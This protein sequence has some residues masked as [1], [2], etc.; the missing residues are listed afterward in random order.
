ML[1]V[2]LSHCAASSADMPL[3]LD[4]ESNRLLLIMRFIGKMW[5]QH[6]QA[7]GERVRISV[8]VHQ[9]GDEPGADQSV[10]HVIPSSPAD[11]DIDFLR[12]VLRTYTDAGGPEAFS[13]GVSPFP[14]STLSNPPSSGQGDARGSQPP[15]SAPGAPPITSVRTA[16][17]GINESAVKNAAIDQA[18]ADL[19]AQRAAAAPQHERGV[20]ALAQGW[21]GP[22][23]L[24][25]TDLLPVCPALPLLDTQSR[26]AVVQSPIPLQDDHV[27]A[28]LQAI[29][30]PNLA[31]F[32]WK[33]IVLFTSCVR[34]L[35]N[36]F[37]PTRNLNRSKPWH[38]IGPN[39]ANKYTYT[40]GT[41][42]Y[43]SVSVN[44]AMVRSSGKHKLE[45][46]VTF[47]ALYTESPFWRAACAIFRTCNKDLVWDDGQ[48]LLRP[49]P[50]ETAE[51]SDESSPGAGKGGDDLG[52]LLADDGSSPSGSDDDE[53]VGERLSKRR[54]TGDSRERKKGGSQKQTGKKSSAAKRRSTSFGGAPG[55]V[56]HPELRRDLWVDAPGLDLANRP[57]TPT[58]LQRSRCSWFWTNLP[59]MGAASLPL[60][61]YQTLGGLFHDRCAKQ[62][63]SV[64]PRTFARLY[65]VPGDGDC[66][67]HALACG[68]MDRVT[69]FPDMPRSPFWK[70]VGVHPGLLR[71]A[72]IA[73]QRTILESSPTALELLET[74]GYLTNIGEPFDQAAVRAQVQD[75]IKLSEAH[76]LW[77][78]RFNG[79]YS[80]MANVL[81][82]I[83]KVFRT[84]GC[85]ANG[86]VVQVPYNADFA[87]A[88]ATLNVVAN[89]NGAN[90]G[91][92]Q[93]GKGALTFEVSATHVPICFVNQARTASLS[94]PAGDQLFFISQKSLELARVS[95]CV[96]MGVVHSG[97]D[98]F[99][100]P[101][102]YRSLLSEF[103]GASLPA[104]AI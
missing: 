70:E 35:V 74:W 64:Q 60:S 99:M 34:T 1:A 22:R 81:Q 100:Y 68:L 45:R 54:K 8:L 5:E 92:V 91:R 9:V 51:D 23:A 87:I 50:R 94:L 83:I 15:L 90:V 3:S 21:Q 18:N 71:W 12:E 29:G 52:A 58:E 32:K 62:Q 11:G 14:G 61:A 76:H 65:D 13:R 28:F 43:V 41:A 40:V 77:M 44:Q 39:V 37:A 31:A 27:A 57:K 7:R 33:T 97:S 72:V 73:M 59:K 102:V 30:A 69:Q 98:H 82:V 67:Y 46:A 56:Q 101:H 36:F 78:G 86:S 25:Y 47:A 49:K 42:S 26:A 93:S 66:F 17:R 2:L 53:A 20:Q 89:E 55:G 16:S 4:G 95:G 104:Y 6:A 80:L 79:D 85:Q 88:D 10:L 75:A 48:D 63:F 103:T 96:V 19:G 84:R 38:E 24:T